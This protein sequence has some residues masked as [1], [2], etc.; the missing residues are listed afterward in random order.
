MV[1]RLT[2][3][4]EV[5]GSIPSPATK[6]SRLVRQERQ[7]KITGYKIMQALKELAF[8]KE[9]AEGVFTGSIWKFEDDDKPTP[10]DAMVAYKNAESKFARMQAAQA[11]YNQTVKVN[12]LGEEMTLS[13]AVKLVGGAGR[14]EKHWRQ[15]AKEDVRSV[16]DNQHVRQKNDTEYARKTI[17]T[18]DAQTEAKKASKYAAALREA[19]QTGNAVEIETIG[20]VPGDF[21]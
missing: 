17:S 1:V 19:I 12:V 9:T 5:D 7:M 4:Q 21:E 14:I 10:Q 18:R 16:F 2:H 6:T 11:W 20:L 3:A 13:L 15:A 8:A